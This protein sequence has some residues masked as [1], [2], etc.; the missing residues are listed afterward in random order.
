[1]TTHTPDE[2]CERLREADRNSVQRCLGSRI[3]AEAADLIQQQQATIERLSAALDDAREV[4]A[5]ACL[6]SIADPHIL[7]ELRELCERAGYG[8]VMSSASA[9]WRQ[10]LGDLAGSEF[11]AGPC[12]STAESTIAKIDNVLGKDAK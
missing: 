3:F 12:R 11:C 7:I 2:I 6:E 10:R 4:L 8:N 9:I 1:M 5:L